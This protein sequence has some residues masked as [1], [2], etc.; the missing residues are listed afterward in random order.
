[1]IVPRIYPITDRR[2][3]GMTHTAQVDV[4][5][6]AGATFIQLREKHLAPRDF[7]EDAR[8]ALAV[9]RRYGARVI[10]NDR[11][12]VAAALGAD[13]VHLGQDDLPPDAARAILG[14]AAII[15][16]S[17]H[18]T[19]QA[20]QASQFPIDYLAFGPIFATATKEKADDVVG[21]EGLARVRA[22]IRE[23]PLV[24]IGGITSSNA[25]AVI[26]A[27]A[28]S[29]ALISAVLIPASTIAQNFRLL[30]QSVQQS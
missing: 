25:A 16:F 17:T 13:G 30:A 8:S 4:L 20:K 11:V 3:T 24:A 5:V 23:L 27:G 21:T 15:G 22:E 18:S 26:A 14:P 2:I 10:I 6:L 28:D 29:L 1:M 19:E 9:A 7:L 12:D